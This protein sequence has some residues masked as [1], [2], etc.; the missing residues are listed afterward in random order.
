MEPIDELNCLMEGFDE[1]NIVDVLN[2]WKDVSTIRKKLEV[3]EESLK[4]KIK[5]HLKE[6]RWNDFYC[7]ANKINVTLS[8]DKRETI[9][10]KQLKLLLNPAQLSQVTRTTTYEKL[11]I[12]TPEMRENMKKFLKKK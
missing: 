4:E 5:A 6:R 12:T 7:E 11:L 3:C 10:T 8:V 2:R 9:D 1:T